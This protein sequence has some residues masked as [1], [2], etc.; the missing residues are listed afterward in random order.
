MKTDETRQTN[1]LRSLLRQHKP[2]GAPMK[3][4]RSIAYYTFDLHAI[5]YADPNQ[6]LVNTFWEARFVFPSRF[7]REVGQI[8]GS[9]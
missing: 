9:K 2:K 3:R 7:R 1:K 5:Y 8:I 6:T 4:T